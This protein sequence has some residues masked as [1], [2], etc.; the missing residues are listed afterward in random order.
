MAIR[1]RGEGG[2]AS[3]AFAVRD[4]SPPPPPHVAKPVPPPAPTAPPFPYV[5]FGKLLDQ[6]HWQ[7]FLRRDQIVV[8]AM[9]ADVLDDQYRIDVI[10]PPVMTVTYLPL[11][12]R[13]TIN[14]G[15][16]E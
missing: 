14:I 2:E 16:D 3:N 4:W 13:M 5:V 7:V 1:P 12:E 8:V 9:A 11:R 10:R 15:G 6:G